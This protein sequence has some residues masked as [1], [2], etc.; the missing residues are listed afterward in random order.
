MVT[1]R[2]SECLETGVTTTVTENT[3]EGT[4]TVGRRGGVGRGAVSTEN[5]TGIGIIGITTRTGTIGEVGTGDRGAGLGGKESPK[6]GRTA[7]EI[8]HTV[9]L[10]E[11]V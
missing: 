7:I 8:D 6:R 10:I 9:I 5:G 2:T 1:I 11:T 4:T 3:R